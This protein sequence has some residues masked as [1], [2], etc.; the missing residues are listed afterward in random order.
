ML[1]YDDVPRMR[2]QDLRNRL[3]AGDDLMVVDVR[4]V[5]EF[6]AE[7]IAGA[8]HVSLADIAK[9]THRLPHD[10]PIVTY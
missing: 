9:G 8:V 2:A 6:A 4:S 10:R 1:Q 5:P 3:Q 7:R